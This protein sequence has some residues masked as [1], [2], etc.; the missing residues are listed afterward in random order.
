MTRSPIPIPTRTPTPRRAL[1][2]ARC[3]LLLAAALTGLGALAVTK[4]ELAQAQA[5]YQQERAACLNGQSPQDRATCLKEAGAA[6]AEARR[7]GLDSD[8]ANFKANQRQRCDQLTGAEQQDCVARMQGRG[9]T[10]GSV[11]GGGILRELVT[12]EVMVPPA[13]AASAPDSAASR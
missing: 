6:L 9:S 13:A 3:A 1:Q 7:G 8:G 12:R 5:G 10:Q 4:A 11:A 2:A